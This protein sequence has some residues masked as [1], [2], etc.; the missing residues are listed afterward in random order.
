MTRPS[1]VALSVVAL[2][3]GGRGATSPDAALEIDAAAT[4]TDLVFQRLADA[5]DTPDQCP[6]DGLPNCY[7]QLA[8]CANRGLTLVLT[9]IAEEGTYDR[10]GNSI[11]GTV[12]GVSQNEMFNATLQP[13]GSLTSPELDGRHP[14][15]PVALD[16]NRKQAVA[17]SCAAMEGRSWWPF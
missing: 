9:D 15:Q 17:D 5:F 12:V 8:L 14:W 4:T 1:L 2:G 13:D 7:A 6:D 11:V 3:C 10:T 16:A